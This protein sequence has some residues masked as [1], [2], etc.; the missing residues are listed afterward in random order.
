MN[1]KSVT[2][3]PTAERREIVARIKA[4]PGDGT[5]QPDIAHVLARGFHAMGWQNPQGAAEDMIDAILAALNG[6]RDE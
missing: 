6:G 4:D 5:V 3:D 1:A 2:S